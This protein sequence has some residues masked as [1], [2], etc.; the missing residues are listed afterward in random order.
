VNA[1]FRLRGRRP[2]Q[3]GKIGVDQRRNIDSGDGVRVVPKVEA[4]IDLKQPQLALRIAFEIEL[5]YAGQ[6]QLLDDG[7]TA[8]AD[9]AGIDDLERRGVAVGDR[10]GTDLAAGELTGD[11]AALVDV[12]VVTFDPGFAAD[13]ELLRQELKP[14]CA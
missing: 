2:R 4:R 13:D 11:A 10:L 9:V 3:S 14:D 8:A 5:G 7:A 12:A 1:G 6:R